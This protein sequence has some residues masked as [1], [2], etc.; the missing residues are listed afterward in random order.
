MSQARNLPRDPGAED[1]HIKQQAA[2]NRGDRKQQRIEQSGL[3]SRI[4]GHVSARTRREQAK[5]DART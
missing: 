5:K 1:K 2:E 4:R 3:K